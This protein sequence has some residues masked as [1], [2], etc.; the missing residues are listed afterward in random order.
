MTQPKIE[1]ILPLTPLQEGLLFH[2]RL[3]REHHGLYVDQYVV[4]LRGELDAARLK[5]SA[6]ALTARHPALRTGFT[7]RRTGEPVQV[8][9]R[10]V[11]VNWRETDLQ[12]LD[13]EAAEARADELADQDRALG[14]HLGTPPLLRHTLITL[15]PRH[16]RLILTAHHIV[17]DGWSFTILF[18]EL[19]ALYAQDST[20]PAARPDAALLPP[21]RPYRDHLAWLAGRDRPAADRAW[22]TTLDGLQE[23][24]LVA[25]PDRAAANPAGT[26]AETV[27]VR[28][29]ETTGT[30][31]TE[32]ARRHGVL[33]STVFQSSWAVVLGEVTGRDD[34]V[35]G[36]TV[37]GRSPELPGA[38]TVIGLL[39]NTVPVRARLAPGLTLRAL[40]EQLQDQRVGLLEHDHRALT[41]IQRTAGLQGP[42]FDTNVVVDNFPVNTTP[43]LPGRDLDVSIRFRDTP[44]HFPL[45]LVV[46]PGPRLEVRLNY[47]GELI[48]RAQ[49]ERLAIRLARLLEQWAADPGRT[50]GELDPLD[51]DERDRILRAWNDT[52]RPLPR[53]T[54][55]ELFEAQVARTPDATAVV[56]GDERLS[57]AALD[58]RATR[59]AGLLTARGI[60][61]EDVVAVAVPRSAGLV[62]AL[63]GVIKAGAAYL[64]IDQGL[65]AQRID[66]M[67]ADAAP[68]LLI[69]TGE[70]GRNLPPGPV[71]R[72]VLDGPDPGPGGPSSTVPAA[73]ARRTPPAPDHPAYVIFTS[74]STGRPKGVLVPHA[75]IVN[76]L[77]WMQEEYALTA[78]DR[79]LQKTPCGFDVS[80]WEFF[81]PLITGA[82]LVVAEPDGHKDPAYLADLIRRESVTTAHFVPSMLSVFLREPAARATASTLR[83]VVCSGEALRPETRTA[84]FDTLDGVELHNLYGPTETAVDVTLWPCRPDPA[85]TTVPI[86]RPAANTRVYVLDTRLRPVAPGTAGELYVTGVQL[87]RG[88][89][90]RPA[91]TAER[92]VACPFEPGSR[93][94]RTGDL[95]RWTGHGT[96]E[97]L[98]RAD[99]QVKIRGFRVEP[100]EVETAAVRC[101][102]VA[103][104]AAVVREDRPG[105]RRL[106]LYAVPAPGAELRP[107]RLREELAG[108]LPE[109][110]VPSAVV[111][112]DALPVTAN[113]KLDR[114]ALPAPE[115]GTGR[116]GRRPRPGREEILAGLFA[117]VLGLPEV[118]AEDDFFAL[119]GD[120]LLAMRL[121]AQA[122]TALGVEL[123]IRQVFATPTVAALAAG[124][125]RFGPARPALRT[126]DRPDALPL[127]SAQRRLW[128]L[129]RSGQG[130][131]YNCPFALRLRGPLDRAALAAALADVVGRH[132]ALRTVFPESGGEPFQRVLPAE[133]T[134]VELDIVEAG[135]GD[136]GGALERLANEEFD[137]AHRPPVRATLLALGEDEHVLALVVHHIALDGWSWRPLFDDLAR[138]YAARR[139]GDGPRWEPLPVQYAD[140]TLWQRELLGEESDPGSVVA[141]QLDFWRKELAGAPAELA[142]PFDRPRP[143]AAS[144]AG[145]SVPVEL[146]AALHARLLELARSRGCTLFMVL[147]AGLAVLLSRLGAGAD[148]PIGTPVAGRSDEALDDVVGFFVNTLVLRTDVSGDPSFVE[149]LSRVREADLAAYEHQDVPFERVV[150]ALNPDRSLARH[151]LFQ[152]MFQLLETTGTLELAGLDVR[153]EPLRFDTAQFDLTVEVRER[154]DAEGGPAGISG[155]L[156]YAAELFD[157]ET[158]ES[159][160]ASLPR[161]LEQLAAEPL[162]P[163][164][165]VEPMT[166]GERERILVDWN[167]T[168]LTTPEATFPRLFEDRVVRTPE[169]TAV[170]HGDTALTFAELNARANRLAHALARHGAGPESLV[171]LALP[172]SEQSVVA[173]LAVLKAG[174]ASVP[175]D[176]EYPAERITL[177]LEDTA[178][179]VVVTDSA[180]A[181]TLPAA[182]DAHLVLID[183]PATARHPHTNP[184]VDVLPSNAAYVIHTSG[185]TG[186]PK[187]VV[188][189]HAGLRN[190]YAFHRAG[191]MTRAEEAR[192]RTRPMRVALTASLSFDTSWEGLL[193]MVAGHELHVIGDDVR[194]DAGA[195]ARHITEAGIDVL[196][197]T[198]TYAEQLIEEGLLDDLRH[199]PR[200]VQLGGEP[201]GAALWTRVREADGIIGVNIYGPTEYT[202]DALWLDLADSDH[203]L[204]GRPLANTRAYVLD[205]ALRPVPPGV[206]GELYLAGAGLARGYLHR[207]ALTAERFVACPFGVAERMYRTGDLARWNRNGALEFLGRA[208]EQVKI[209]GFR[210]EPGEIEAALVRVPG[211]AQAAVT[212]REDGPV[213]KRL[214][215][216]VVPAAGRTLEAAALRREVAAVLPEHMVPSAFM[217]LEAFPLTP[218]GKLD[219]KALPSP[220]RTVTASRAPRTPREEILTGLFAEILGVPEAG[221]EDGFF[222][223]GGHSLLATR[224]ISRAR[225][226]LGVEL[227][228]RDLFRAQT[229]AALAAL[230]GDAGSAR[231]PLVRGQHTDHPPLS[232]AQHRLWFVHQAEEQAATYNMPFAA[233]LQG[234]LDVTALAEALADVAARHETLRTLFPDI[235]GHPALRVLPPAEARPELTAEDV[236]GPEL[237][238]AIASL[239]AH[240]FDLAAEAPLRARL[241]RL[242]PDEHVLL[243]VMH[244]IAS[245]GLSMEPL[246]RDLARAYED[247]RQGNQPGWEPLPVRYTDYTLWQRELL[248]EE[249]DPDSV[250]SRQLDFWGKELAGAPAELALPFDRPR[251]AVA[252][253]DGGSVPVRLGPELHARLS[254]LARSQGCTLFMVLQ[255]GLAVLLSRLGAGT[256]LPIG[257]PVAG[258]ADEALDDLVGFFV[259]TLVLRTDVSG[260]PSFVDLLAR[261]R[262]ADLAAYEHQDVPFERVVEAL[263]PDRSP[264]RHPLF[265]VM[266]QLQ[267]TPT[268]SLELTGLTTGHRPVPFGIAKFD[269]TL[270]MAERHGADGTPDGLHGELTYATE[271]FTAETAQHLAA[272]LEALFGIVTA[273][274]DRPFSALTGLPA[275]R[276]GTVHRTAEEPPPTSPASTGEATAGGATEQALCALFAEVLEVDSV[277]PDDNFFAL[278]GHSLQVTRLISRVRAELGLE[279]RIRQVFQHPTPAGVAA[280]LTAAPKARPA[281]RRSAH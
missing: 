278:G 213:G 107:A 175:V 33:L 180:T 228:I 115:H 82:A 58:A 29:A 136:L 71:P 76:R 218:N 28:L 176:L 138:A 121:V 250:A 93:M 208:D 179:A 155:A 216:Y 281:L 92:F 261:V 99:D 40:G 27:V 275:R 225:T 199:R 35:F 124:L 245:D 16:H 241:F 254:E 114:K 91:L 87:A 223:L 170:V 20:G 39:I 60:G 141:R 143:A 77:L 130:A 127:S 94:Y 101:G 212:V 185:S 186:R 12:R 132:E 161:V 234:T 191:L 42:L 73:L 244:H 108:T 150:E 65:P 198:P 205:E 269:L 266:L 56:F 110:M 220:D 154:R 90:G 133:A 177:L 37:S 160:A 10:D 145:G 194:R 80:V 70:A 66:G 146:D 106:V 187:G 264:A 125:D 89:T 13:S 47:R 129:S 207:P 140:Y 123:G 53:T 23:P 74:G 54:L 231:P 167:D 217:T 226:A 109:H 119:G 258:R 22:R 102:G 79:V 103:Q 224:L 117:T 46:E 201:T 247:R 156:E 173:L 159:L 239:T 221:A 63:Y 192:G 238:R 243:L 1:D 24:T 163:V 137:L 222:D 272:D 75:A 134:D 200:V 230:A 126:V 256:D 268:D 235:D 128:F 229:P 68:A 233:R 139:S 248:G 78:A 85:A 184:G 165:R 162:R 111:V 6:A 41:D 30:A 237:D 209:R 279:L 182:G 197:I 232:H 270:D 44:T 277:G 260:D 204:V 64:P 113:G 96:L 21:A 51:G 196:D 72:L 265:Q 2:T 255:A 15:A 188:V 211:V 105:D 120:S 52:A 81:W 31:L 183:D 26:T 195:M 142:L 135:D 259:N 181:G 98:G 17:V 267:N 202:I 118:G 84:F 36:C 8:V 169:A 252:S 251:P 276:Q 55:P 25:P 97:Y 112:L 11:P 34:V 32:R 257:T 280:G 227:G 164:G 14:V 242:A 203:P 48:D 57:Y 215:A 236:T 131:G 153:N 147:Q 166:A 149:L 262:E 157:P 49:V 43:A 38:D 273:D 19:F 152:V 158:A 69:T 214:A 45:T 190:L 249:S 95:V 168:A 9:H 210:V 50:L 3:D 151:P 178:P 172:R 240:R 83:R 263:N 5:A 189:D 144:H 193:W 174:A 253:Y 116:G 67:L 59:L 7:H 100:G 61:P 148:L 88:Y 206:A 4:E 86:G 219:R 246:L 122:R 271:L 104:A 171:A 18:D 62:V 274:P